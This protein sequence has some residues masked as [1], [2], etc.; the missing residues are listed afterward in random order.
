MPA[1]QRLHDHRARLVRLLQH[2][3]LLRLRERSRLVPGHRP[4]AGG[5]GGPQPP[6]PAPALARKAPFVDTQ[7]PPPPPP[8]RGPPRVPP[9]PPPPP[10]GGGPRGAAPPLLA[11]ELTRRADRLFIKF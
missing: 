9:P 2:L 6:A 7:P 11:S 5:R 3:H 10:R 8:R 1:L 4:H